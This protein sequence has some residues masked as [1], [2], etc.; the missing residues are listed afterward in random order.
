MK[1]V[2]L[3]IIQQ[4]LE[5]EKLD[6]SQFSIR[7]IWNQEKLE[8]HLI[9][10]IYSFDL[11]VDAETHHFSLEYRNYCF[12][13]IILIEKKQKKERKKKTVVWSIVFVFSCKTHT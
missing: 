9:V 2:G 10:C 1:S 6:V 13:T 11:E 4:M 5:N 7:L 8:S 3:E 12:T